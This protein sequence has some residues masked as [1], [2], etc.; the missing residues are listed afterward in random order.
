MS[1]V[2]RLTV[3]RSVLSRREMTLLIFV[4]LLVRKIFKSQRIPLLRA[5]EKSTSKWGIKYETNSSKE[6]EETDKLQFCREL[7][8]ELTPRVS[9]KTVGETG[10]SGTVGKQYGKYKTT[11]RSQEQKGWH[12]RE[13]RKRAGRVDKRFPVDWL[14]S[15]AYRCLGTNLLALP[16]F[17]SFS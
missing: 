2:N 13:D 4:L 3:Q 15:V 8:S 1:L 16:L 7:I 14:T 12:A 9:C 10:S 5:G 6:R 11:R 17:G